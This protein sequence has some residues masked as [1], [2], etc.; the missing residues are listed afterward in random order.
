M[1]QQFKP[2]IKF[3]FFLERNKNYPNEN[4]LRLFI[5]FVIE[6]ES[7]SSLGFSSKAD[8]RVKKTLW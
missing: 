5:Q 8:R 3:F 2:G 1:M 4:K 6:R 7:A